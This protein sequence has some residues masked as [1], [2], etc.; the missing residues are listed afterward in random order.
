M[1]FRNNF[2]LKRNKREGRYIRFLK[3]ALFLT[4]QSLPPVLTQ[5]ESA[6]I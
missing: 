5:E 2:N 3:V 4:R 6:H 1:R